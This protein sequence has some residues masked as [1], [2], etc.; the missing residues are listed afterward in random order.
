MA[1]TNKPNGIT[2]TRD[3]ALKFAVTW[4][5]TDRDY[6]E[7]QQVRMRAK[8]RNGKFTDWQTADVASNF[9]SK[10]FTFTVA[11]FNPNAGQQIDYIEVNVRGKRART[12]ENNKT[13]IYDWSAWAAKTLT[14]SAPRVP[15]ASAELTETNQSE[16]SWEVETSN[17][18]NRPFV[19]TKWETILKRACTEKDG[20]KLSWVTTNPGWQT[21]TGSATGT[22]TKTEEPERLAADS[23]TRWYRFKSRGA[24]G[25]SAWRYTYH[26]YARPYA[27]KIKSVKA[28]DNGTSTTITAKWSAAQDFA[29]PIDQVRVEYAIVTPAAGFTCPSGNIWSTGTT[30]QDG[31]KTDS[32]QFIVNDTVGTDE[33]LFVRVVTIHDSN[34]TASDPKTV[35]AGAMEP[36]TITS[37]TVNDTTHRVTITA[38]NHSAVPDAQLAVIFRTQGVNT[39]VGVI[40]S[41][42]SATVQCPN[43]GTH[44]IAIG[45]KAF[46]GTYKAKAGADGVTIYTLVKNMQSVN[47]WRGGD[48]PREA[49]N[50]TAT[51]A[52]DAIGE[53]ILTWDWTWTEANAAEL[54]WS[55]NPNAWE[56]TDQPQTF[57]LDNTNAAQWRIAGLETGVT[58]YFAVRLMNVSDDGNTVYGAYSEIVSVN[59]STAPNVPILA[60][61][62]A[63]VPKSGTVEATW[64]YV[65]TDGTGQAL[66]EVFT[67]SVNGSTVTP[68]ELVGV[69]E[70]ARHASISAANWTAGETYNLIV[71]VTSASGMVS[72]WSDPVSVVVAE[73]LVCTIDS[74]SLQT[75]TVPDGDTGNT[76]TETGLTDLPLT[77]TVTGAGAG[78]TTTV[79][80]ERAAEYPLPR[81]DGTTTGGYDGE[82][83]A[84]ITQPGEGQIS[85]NYGDLI[86]SLDDGAH[87]RL[88]AIVEDGFGQTETESIDFWVVWAHQA[89]MPGGTVTMQDGVA[90]IT[91]TAPSNY[92]SGDTA[93]I[94][95]LSVDKPQLIV[96]G[97]V[98]GTAYVDP[99][100]AVGEHAGYRIVTRTKNGDYIMQDN[101][102]A[103]YNITGELI[104]NESGFINFNGETLPIQYN[105]TVD[106]SARKDFKEVKYLGGSVKGFWNPGISKAGTITAV[107]PTTDT[108]TIQMIR[109]LEDWNGICHVRSQDG[110]SFAANVDV[111]H[112]QGYDTA[113]KVERYTLNI[114]RIQPETLDGM[115]LSEWTVNA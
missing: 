98:F 103:W 94:Y 87:Y 29:H 58:W 96:S 6:A 82:T 77:V 24:A 3:G 62:A 21:G 48:V 105:A 7:G 69:A 107:V 78:G 83:I 91:P 115:P 23:Y 1:S 100:P 18:D 57:T 81:P 16:Y 44:D 15:S 2:L 71:R 8:K 92:A 88:I 93:D 70:S 95:R 86:G 53:V 27:A 106:G 30:L 35:K 110:A 49:Q 84:H 43:W 26:T 33:C 13:T 32:A 111:S 80:I 38:A 41:G 99:F 75:V 55:Q 12:T 60:L 89:G 63:V 22:L 36:P 114:T 56:S 10:N 73:D 108:E 11:N 47:V 40:T 113:G 14:L 112:G 50:L 79:F 65:T 102:F 104:S 19:H 59:L 39:I 76:K 52:P 31:G 42:T 4:K 64:D 28:I 45:V 66:A 20:S 61:S 37:V 54:S 25:D 97:A 17:D 72:A 67:A 101:T 74:T 34:E 46:Q 9:T 5:V 51:P 68:G 109:R 90:V 85:I